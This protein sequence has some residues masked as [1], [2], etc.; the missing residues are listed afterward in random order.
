MI[1]TQNCQFL[2]SKRIILIVCKIFLGFKSHTFYIIKIPWEQK[3]NSLVIF[4]FSFDGRVQRM[5]LMH[6]ELPTLFEVSLHNECEIR[7]EDHPCTKLEMWPFKH[8]IN[9]FII[10]LFYVSIYNIIIKH[11]SPHVCPSVQNKTSKRLVPLKIITTYKELSICF[12]IKRVFRKMLENCVDIS[13]PASVCH[14]IS[15]QSFTLR[16]TDTVCNRLMY[17]LVTIWSE[18]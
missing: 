5:I 3:S 16:R 13:Q 11:I 7:W 10:K 2:L 17:I 15:C 14:G 18:I 4:T 1:R 8:S 12:R 6:S 9:C